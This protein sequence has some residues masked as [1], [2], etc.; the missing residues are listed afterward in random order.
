MMERR[1]A[2]AAGGGGGGTRGVPAPM[3][4]RIG[5]AFDMDPV[6]PGTQTA[7]G[8]ALCGDV[9][10]TTCVTPS[11]IVG[12]AT[13]I[14]RKTLLCGCRT[15]ECCCAAGGGRGGGPRGALTETRCTFG[16]PSV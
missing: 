2:R 13:T 1:G 3:A 12:G 8:V 15:D 14:P 16:K 5:L 6:P 9:V 7:H 10:S 4:P 11:G